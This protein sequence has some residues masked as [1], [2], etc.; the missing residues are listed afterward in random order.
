MPVAKRFR[1]AKQIADFAWLLA[2]DNDGIKIETRSAMM[3]MTT[4][5]SIRVKALRCLAMARSFPKIPDP[6]DTPSRV[7]AEQDGPAAPMLRLSLNS[8]RHFDSNRRAIK[9]KMELID[10]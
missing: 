3:A 8:I 1:L 7:H 9:K 2:E 10:T 6:S 5:N 4:S